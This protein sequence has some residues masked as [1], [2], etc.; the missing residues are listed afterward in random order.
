M[1]NIWEQFIQGQGQSI[2]NQL[3]SGSSLDGGGSNK[4][5]ADIVSLIISSILNPVMLLLVAGAIVYFMWGALTYVQRGE[6]EGDR[7][8]GVNMMWY[9]I[10]AI[11]VMISVWGLVN[12]LINTF[13]LNTT[14]PAIPKL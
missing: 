11:F 1:G 2:F 4:D 9:G 14:A 12:I 5:F 8:K 6:D 7:A 13:D 10:V 3:T